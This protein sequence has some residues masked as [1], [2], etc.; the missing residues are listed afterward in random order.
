M[1]MTIFLAVA[2]VGVSV[3]LLVVGLYI[4]LDRQRIQRDQALKERLEEFTVEATKDAIA[5]LRTTAQSK[6]VLDKAFAG[7]KY[8]QLIEEMTARGGLNWSVGHV[9]GLVLLG[10]TVGLLA[11]V[12]VDRYLAVAIGVAG[13]AAP[14]LYLARKRA[15]REEKI[16]EQL[17]EAVDMLVN[18]LRAGYSLPAAMNFVGSEIPT[19]LG[20]EFI[21]FYDEQ[22]LGMDVRQ[23]L[24]N[25]QE[26]LGTLDSRMFALA[27]TI[28]RETGG[29]LSEILGSIATV[30]RDRMNFR[31]QVKVMTAEANMSAIILAV[32]PVAMY[33]MMRILNPEYS[34]AL[35][36]TETG[37]LMLLYGAVSVTVGYVV[38]RRMAAVRL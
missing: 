35:T 8:A 16:E 11:G 18:S 5:I 12:L 38:L 36:D 33:I 7:G 27:I 20:P 25:L 34:A 37:R 15:E 10:L 9:A 23:A 6:S 28:Q 17:P 2:A 3:A 19:P 4:W 29:N 24:D 13:A 14:L 21:R 31:A 22:R 32:L 1:S 26:R 30:I